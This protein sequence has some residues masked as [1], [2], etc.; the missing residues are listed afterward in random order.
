MRFLYGNTLLPPPSRVVSRLNSLPLPFRTPA[1][2]A[3]RI[4][5][6]GTENYVTKI[7]G[8]RASEDCP[9]WDC[10]HTQEV[11]VQQEI[12]ET[13]DCPKGR[14]IRKLMAGAGEVQKNFRARQ[15]TLKNIQAT[16]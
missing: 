13:Y 10:S 3:I 6:N 16:P 11:T 2:Q 12:H 15:L 9:P 14:T 7:P 1:T 4:V 8:N 5:K